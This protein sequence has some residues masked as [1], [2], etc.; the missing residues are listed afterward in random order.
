MFVTHKLTKMN[1]QNKSTLRSPEEDAARS[2]SRALVRALG[3]RVDK[4]HHNHIRVIA[5][6][7]WP[8]GLLT[9]FHG[10]VN[11]EQRLQFCVTD[12][13]MVIDGVYV[14]SIDENGDL[15][16][17]IRTSLMEENP[18]DYQY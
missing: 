16:Q 9:A 7:T 13:E 3:S 12:P 4:V 15:A 10:W 6:E 8:K 1:H 17:E 14:V 18:R 2:R 5:C 11:L